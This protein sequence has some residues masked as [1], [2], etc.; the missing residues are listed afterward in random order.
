MLR[1]T[2]ARKAGFFASSMRIQCALQVENTQPPDRPARLRDRRL[3]V[4]GGR[5]GGEQGEQGGLVS[6]PAEASK[7]VCFATHAPP[8]PGVAV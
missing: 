8:E 3:L 5:R 2:Q 1:A 4:Q 6:E 7:V